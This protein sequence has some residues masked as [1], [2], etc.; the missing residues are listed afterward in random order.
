MEGMRWLI[1]AAL[2]AACGRVGFDPL[3]GG[4]GTP[5]GDGS[6][7]PGSDGNTPPPA[8]DADPPPVDALAAACQQAIPATVN[9]P[10]S[11]NTCDTGLDRV[12]GCGGSALDELVFVFTAPAAGSYTVQTFDGSTANVITT[13]EVNNTCAGNAGCFGIRQTSWSAGETHYFVVESPSGACQNIRFSVS[14]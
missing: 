2:L 5:T 4:G 1:A 8:G 6:N 13:G 9:V 14:M 11:K 12:D 10:I 3:S 7:P